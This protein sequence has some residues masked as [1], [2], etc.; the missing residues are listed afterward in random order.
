MSA[1][2]P[3]PRFIFTLPFPPT[4]FFSHPLS[5]S[6]GAHYRLFSSSKGKELQRETYHS[7]TG[8]Y[9]TLS[10]NRYDINRTYSEDETLGTCEAKPLHDTMALQWGWLGHAEYKGMKEIRHLQVE[11]WQMV[12]PPL[13]QPAPDGR[14]SLTLYVQPKQ[15]EPFQFDIATT[16][17]YYKSVMYFDWRTTAT[18]AVYEVPD[19]CPN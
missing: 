8:D 17:G 7:T 11:T 9:T 10:L 4:P 1:A 15:N 19:V 5:L 3:P 13:A 6:K 18:A 2:P 16:A 14:T 12:I